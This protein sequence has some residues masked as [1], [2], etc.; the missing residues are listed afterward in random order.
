[1]G[2]RGKGL[3]FGTAGIPL[4]TRKSSYLTGIERI[5]EL[6]LGGMELEFVYGVKVNRTAAVSI[7]ET[8]Q[9]LGIRLSAHSP[10]WINLNS[11]D[12]LKQEASRERILQSA[13]IGSLS[14]AR[15]IVFHPAF[16]MED[17]PEKVLEV[18]A[19]NIKTIQ[20]ELDRDGVDVVLRPEVSGKVAAFGS[21]D[22]LLELTARLAKVSPC[23]DF[24]HCHARTGGVNT[25]NEIS[26]LI[27][28]ISKRLGPQAL[29]D[30]H[31]HISGIAYGKSGE[32]KHLNLMESDLNYHEILHAL[33]DSACSG[34]V[35]C[36]SPN[37]EEDALLLQET[38][39]KMG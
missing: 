29:E 20:E 21:V 36:E 12:P 11:H 30:M 33:A 24:A 3:L 4:S 18:V 13:R 25:Y 8:A 35:I 7:K 32:L 1:M 16:Y 28:K 6:G 23:F 19:T 5:R 38:Y 14:G 17:P 15:S 39:H 2:R 26:G 27:K 22:E 31:I 34:L 10:Y 9:R 37:L